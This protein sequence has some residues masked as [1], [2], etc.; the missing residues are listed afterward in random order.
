LWIVL[1]GSLFVT[2]LLAMYGTGLRMEPMYLVYILCA[3]YFFDMNV[4]FF[5]IAFMILNYLGV[6][7]YLEVN[8]APLEDQINSPSNAFAFIYGA[9][10]MWLTANKFLSENKNFLQITNNQ[11]IKLGAQN[12]ELERFAFVAAHD[13]KTPLRNLNN[14]L[15]LID[16][17]YDHSNT[18]ISEYINTSK[19][20]ASRLFYLINDILEYSKAHLENEHQ[21][22]VDLNAL[23]KDIKRNFSL[24]LE[25]KQ[26]I[27]DQEKLPLVYFDQIQLRLI[28]Q[29]IIE[30]GL[31]YNQSDIPKINIIGQTSDNHYIIKVSDN[32]IGIAEEYIDKIFTMFSRLHTYDEYVGSGL[33]LATVKRILDNNGASI[34]VQSK[35]NEGTTFIISL[36]AKLVSLH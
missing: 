7:Y 18:K 1:A 3:V 21:T 27:I 36:P 25:S 9:F 4:S 11:N 13:L 17:K 26:I 24:E 29:N 2:N 32:G 19:E 15:G 34:D 30:N 23:I 35:S 28:F 14:Y 22:W 16:M 33:G 31:K 10:M 8:P 12:E 5:L 20:S 6:L